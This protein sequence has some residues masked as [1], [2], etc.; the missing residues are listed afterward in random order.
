[1]RRS[2]ILPL[3]VNLLVIAGLL[4]SCSNDQPTRRRARISAALKDQAPGSPGRR[5]GATPAPAADASSAPEGYTPAPTTG[6]R[7]VPRESE[8]SEFRGL[9]LRTSD[10]SLFQPCGESRYYGVVGTGEAVYLLRERYRF[11]AVVMGRPLFGVFRGALIKDSSGAR[12]RGGAGAAAPPSTVTT[13]FFLVHPDTLRAPL[14][15]DCRTKA[16]P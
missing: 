12:S 6:G 9:Y 8:V 15:S 7:R 1:M 5:S 4:S 13:R 10:S 16:R 11:T 14:G 3:L 2:R